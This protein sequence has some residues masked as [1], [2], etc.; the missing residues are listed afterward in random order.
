M[1][2]II[3]E[4]GSNHNGDLELAKEMLRAAVETGVNAVKFQTFKADLL[5]SKTA[6]KAEYQKN[7][8]NDEESQYDML[9]RLEFSNEDYL[10][11][12][13]LGES[14]GVDV[15]S[16]AFDEDSINF[17]ISTGMN[18]FKVPSGELTNLPFLRKVGSQKKKIIIST[19]MA[20]IEEVQAACKVLEESGSDDITILHCTTDYPTRPEDINL[21]T[22]KTLQSEFPRFRIGF[23]DHSLGSAAA[24]AV[25][26]MGI[27]VIEKH[28]TTDNTLPGPDQHASAMPKTMK[29]L[30]D[31]VRVVEK[32]MGSGMLIPTE[33]EMENRIV[34]RKSLVAKTH[35]KKGDMFS[36]S[37]IT[38]KRPGDGI[39]PMEIDSLLGKISLNNYDVDEKISFEELDTNE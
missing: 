16:T 28:F 2:Y 9:K 12:K 34:A 18:I 24:I 26:S 32:A 37:N 20:T 17:L 39:S 10:E 36:E 4:I 33:T 29:E 35:V 31:G 6:P 15:F 8:A 13:K 22:I 1:I 21:N 30:V 3:A 27:T 23:S 14:L 19:G 5:L 11:V 38:V 7:R 25:A